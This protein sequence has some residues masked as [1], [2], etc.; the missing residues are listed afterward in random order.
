MSRA[1]ACEASSFRCTVQAIEGRMRSGVTVAT[2]MWST[3]WTSTPAASSAFFA[4]SVA[5]S[6]FSWPGATMRRSRMPVRV[7]IHSSDVST[8]FSR[9]ALDSTRSGRARPVPAM[10]APRRGLGFGMGGSQQVEDVR[11]DALLDE[12]RGGA[13]RAAD[14]ARGRAAVAD[15]D[16]AVDAEQWRAA[17]LGVVEL[18]LQALERRAHEQRAQLRLQA[19]AD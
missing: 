18:L 2:K 6:E 14:G 11:V 10:V 16:D 3:S 7:T 1:A 9:S 5:R 12:R 4:A 19:S 15:E 8:I 13:D 17:V